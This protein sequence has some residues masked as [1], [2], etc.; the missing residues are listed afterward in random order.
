[1]SDNLMLS[2]L[3]QSVAG[4]GRAQDE[5]IRNTLALAFFF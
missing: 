5:S 2:V 1:M 4:V 3:D